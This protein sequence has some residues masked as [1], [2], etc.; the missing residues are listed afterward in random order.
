MIHPERLEWKGRTFDLLAGTT[1]V[2]SMLERGR[3]PDQVIASWNE[4]LQAFKEVRQ[5]Y[6]LY[7]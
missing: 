3:T 4:S 7:P 1:I 2:R 5:K 6:L